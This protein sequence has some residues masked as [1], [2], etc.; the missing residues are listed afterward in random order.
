VGSSRRRNQK[1][2]KRKTVNEEDF[3]V[4]LFETF[5]KLSSSSSSHH[6]QNSQTSIKP[7]LKKKSSRTSKP[8]V[9]SIKKL[10]KRSLIASLEYFQAGILK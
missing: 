10:K 9:G 8:P 2:V 3:D 7:Y 5:L 4:K 1:K 6:R